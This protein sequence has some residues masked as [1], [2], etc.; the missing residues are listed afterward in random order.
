MKNK[1]GFTL[2]EV[3]TTLAI[4][5]VVAALA[6]PAMVAQ[7]NK[8]KVGP[9]LRKFKNTI[10][11]TNEHILGDADERQL[12]NAVTSNQEY[13]KKLVQYLKGAEKYESNKFLLKD[14]TEFVLS[15]SVPITVDSTKLR[16][17]Y[18]GPWREIIVDINGLDNKPNVLG[19]DKFA[20]YIDDSGSLIPNGGKEQIYAGYEGTI[21]DDDIPA[22]W[23]S[24]CGKDKAIPTKESD[25]KSCTG[26]I[27]DNEWK[28]V[29][30]Y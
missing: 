30:K 6:A 2:V 15:A 23:T 21:R 10:E 27:A 28:I 25:A 3:L 19:R 4:I 17:S 16:G 12:S 9:T 1:K 26:S 13:F 14:G 8:S 22:N 7:V 20:F 29:Y 18:K 11:V 24:F 5:G